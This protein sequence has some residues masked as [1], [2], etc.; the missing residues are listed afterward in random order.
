MQNLWLRFKT[1]CSRYSLFAHFVLMG[2]NAFLTSWATKT[3]IPLDD[4]GSVTINAS[5]WMSDFQRALHINT[6]LLGVLTF[7]VNVYVFYRNW[8]RTHP[9][10]VK[11][12][13]EDIAN[14]TQALADE[15]KSVAVATDQLDATNVGEK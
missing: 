5:V 4:S 3:A 9:Q 10:I 2:W 8:K 13:A 12:Q 7:L 1:F 14:K 15:A 6:K 11:S